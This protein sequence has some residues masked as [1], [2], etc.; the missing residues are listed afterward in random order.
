MAKKKVGLVHR[1][2][3]KAGEIGEKH[4]DTLVG[5]LRETYGPGFAKGRRADLRLDNLLKDAKCE[6][7]SEYLKKKK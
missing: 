4:G 7:L 3:G 5:T 1:V 2:R 6:S